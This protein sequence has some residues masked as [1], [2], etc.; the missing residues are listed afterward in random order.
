MSAATNKV[1]SLLDEF[2]TRTPSDT[3]IEKITA[4]I[5]K[6]DDESA[7]APRLRPLADNTEALAALQSGDAN[8]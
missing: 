4:L 2:K 7:E 6:L 8:G 3:A 1:F 5:K